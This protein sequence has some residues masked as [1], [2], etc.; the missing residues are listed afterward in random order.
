MIPILVLESHR[1]TY[2]TITITGGTKSTEEF[3]EI[4]QLPTSSK[5]KLELDRNTSLLQTQTQTKPNNEINP[6]PM[7]Y[8]D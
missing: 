2:P 3:E 8:C 1:A 7:E 6:H 5:N 4:P